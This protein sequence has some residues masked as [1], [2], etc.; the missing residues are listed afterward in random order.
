MF[1]SKLK[2]DGGATALASKVAEIEHL[3][4]ERFALSDHVSA[5]KTRA[6][7]L[8]DDKAALSNELKQAK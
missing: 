3:H 7:Q 5:E 6:I 8:E 1:A 4:K 2:L